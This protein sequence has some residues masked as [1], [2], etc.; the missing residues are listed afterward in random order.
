[1][2]GSHAQGCLEWFVVNFMES[3]D[4]FLQR[5]MT[6]FIGGDESVHLEAVGCHPEGQR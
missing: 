1:M 3:F 6:T 2:L 5:M 4:L